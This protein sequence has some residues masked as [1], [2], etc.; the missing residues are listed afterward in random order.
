MLKRD[1]KSAKGFTL[2]E[3]VVSMLISALLAT[4]LLFSINQLR[5]SAAVT[6]QLMT[7]DLRA[8]LLQD[9]LG[10][11]LAGAIMLEH[12]NIER[13]FFGESMADGSLQQLTFIT[14][15]PLSV[16]T[17]SAQRLIRVQYR[18][19]AVPSELGIT[20]SYQLYRR[21]SDQLALTALSKAP[22]YLMINEIKSLKIKYLIAKA[23][24]KKSKAAAPLSA[25]TNGAP[26]STDA[27]EPAPAAN[28][29]GKK[30]A[31]PASTN[32]DAAGKNTGDATPP[33]PPGREPGT[34][35]SA[36]ELASAGDQADAAAA[37][38]LPE[39]DTKQSGEF[40]HLP[41]YV[42]IELELWQDATQQRSQSF[43]YRLPI[44]S[45][46]HQVTK[47]GGASQRQVSEKVGDTEKPEQSNSPSKQTVE[48][49]SHAP[50]KPKA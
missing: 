34:P 8:T 33:A 46:Q 19:E 9:Q 44:Y 4:A 45:Y 39:F 13:P 31:T 37:R 16:F 35:S 38:P 20:S 49:E 12:G 29:T 23:P 18:L 17:A 28:A 48:K 10:R 50:K 40:D 30:P 14:V 47:A 32:P 1:H 24:A 36:A 3:L 27:A 25:N 26:A 6:E 21:E 41:A 7:L 43:Q 15:N 42:E 5:K 2:L 22:E 11:D